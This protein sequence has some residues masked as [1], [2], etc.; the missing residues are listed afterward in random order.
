MIMNHAVGVKISVAQSG[1]RSVRIVYLMSMAGALL[2]A[3]S[4]TAQV[5]SWLKPSSGS[6]EEQQ[7]SG[8]SPAAGQTILITNAGWKSVMI[9]PSTMQAYSGSLAVDSITISSPVDSHNV[10]LLNYAGLQTPVTVKAMTVASNAEVNMM[11]SALVLNGPNGTGMSIC[12]LFTQDIFSSV[13][14]N[15]FDVGYIGAGVYNLVSGTLNVGNAW[16]GGP[17]QGMF[18]QS[19]GTNLTQITHLESG[20]TYDLSGGDFNSTVYFDGGIFRQHGGICHGLTVF[21]G[22]YLLDS[23]IKQGGLLLPIN[24]GYCLACGSARAVQSGGTNLGPIQLG[25]YGSGS[26]TLSNGVSTSSSILV[27]ARGFFQQWNGTQTITGTLETVSAEIDRDYYA[28]GWYALNGGMLSAGELDLGGHYTQS[29][30]TNLV[31]GDVVLNGVLADFTMTGGELRCANVD[32]YGSWGGGFDVGGRM[33]VANELAVRGSTTYAWRGFNLNAPGQLQVSNIVLYPGA[34]FYKGGG[35]LVQS[36]RLTL[37]NANL[38]LA[39]GTHRFGPVN[40]AAPS[41]SQ[42]NSTLQM[43]ASNA[44]VVSFGDSRSLQWSNTATLTI[45]NWAGSPNGGGSHQI[46]FGVSSSAL[47]GAQL[48]QVIFDNPAGFAAGLYPARILANGEIIPDNLSATG[49]PRPV[50]GLW[51]QTDGSMQLL[52]RGDAGA[53]YRIDVS[54]NLQTWASWTNVTGAGSAVSTIDSSATNRVRRF[55]RAVEVP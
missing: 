43:P 21:Q 36:G 30:G 10:L 16:V 15:Q 7:W 8:G 9:S 24:N 20:G 42:I 4:A 33:V 52:L 54:S 39:G 29:G 32:I 34:N 45:E 3:G 40:L 53:H 55:Y 31:A 25:T 35:A 49:N 19:G 11:S 41:S 1:V 46:V 50:L 17:F 51:R 6:W 37:M 28:Y 26:Y 12:G 14:G 47:T 22:T 13:T 44:C 38:I 5:N 23:G 48:Q 2:V 18:N 27:D